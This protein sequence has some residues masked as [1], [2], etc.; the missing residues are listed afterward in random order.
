MQRPKKSSQV[1]HACFPAAELLKKMRRHYPSGW[2]REDII[3]Y[4]KGKLWEAEQ[5]A[6][7]KTVNLAD[8]DSPG[9]IDQSTR[10]TIQQPMPPN[11]P[12][13]LCFLAWYKFGSLGDN[14]YY[15][16]SD[17]G[18]GPHLCNTHQGSAWEPRSI[19]AQVKIEGNDKE[20]KRPFPVNPNPLCKSRRAIHEAKNDA[21]KMSHEDTANMTSAE[22]RSE[23]AAI[24]RALMALQGVIHVHNELDLWKIKLKQAKVLAQMVPMAENK[25][26]Y[27]ELLSHQP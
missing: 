5:E 10:Q 9:N 21:V 15:I 1:D 14:H 11:W 20:N 18:E 23:D 4:V 7:N 27:Y 16:C 13:P 3:H 19:I 26:N 12:G 25:H 8:Q 17:K 22:D 24:C 2:K 6:K